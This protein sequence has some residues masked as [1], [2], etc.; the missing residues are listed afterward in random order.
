MNIDEKAF[1]PATS[2]A[3]WPE[4]T[5]ISRKTV[6]ARTLR[7]R[8]ATARAKWPMYLPDVAYRIECLP[9]PRRRHGRSWAH[10]PRGRSNHERPPAEGEPPR[11]VPP[12]RAPIHGDLH[13]RVAA[14][15]QTRLARVRAEP[16]GRDRPLPHLRVQPKHGHLTRIYL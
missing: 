15:P 7:R 16:S 6:P 14:D 9:P 12:L 1:T 5:L 8:R 10:P 11:R 2:I 4:N 13:R 3:T